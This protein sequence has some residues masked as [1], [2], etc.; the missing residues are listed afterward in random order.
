M[1][2]LLN[3]SR[4]ISTVLLLAI[5]AV[6]VL[7]Q[8]AYPR[9]SGIETAQDPTETPPYPNPIYTAQ[10]AISRTLSYLPD[11]LVVTQQATRLVTYTTVDEW[12]DVVGPNSA[13]HPQSPV[14][15]VG[16]TANALSV[17]D[18]LGDLEGFV[19]DFSAVE[20]AFYIWDANGGFVAGW[21]VLDPTTPQNFSTLLALPETSATIVPAT[22]EPLA[23]PIPTP[24]GGPTWTPASE[25]P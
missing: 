6:L 20:G 8:L 10:D 15:L 4:S 19:D 22:V 7:F 11:D 5:A 18:V 24:T 17:A 23:T 3:P 25:V 21:G 9:S 12:R 13:Q 2:V 1:R 14:W 16:V